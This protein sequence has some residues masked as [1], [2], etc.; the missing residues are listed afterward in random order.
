[1]SLKMHAWMIC[2]LLKPLLMHIEH[3]YHTS[4]DPGG[5]KWNL[6]EAIRTYIDTYKDME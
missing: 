1:M 2:T 5:I 3:D 4:P 6:V